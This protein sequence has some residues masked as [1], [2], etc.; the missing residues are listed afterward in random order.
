LKKVRKRQREVTREGSWTIGSEE[1]PNQENSAKI[2]TEDQ[3]IRRPR[4]GKG[5]YQE[6]AERKGN[7]VSG[8]KSGS[9]VSIRIRKQTAQTRV[10]GVY[11]RWVGR[12]QG[13]EWLAKRPREKLSGENSSGVTNSKNPEVYGVGKNSPHT[14]GLIYFS[15]PSYYGRKKGF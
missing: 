2:K 8:K 1:T 6:G 3:N 5:V 9:R 14:Q 13:D 4:L 12:R 15:W 11:K 10:I 7:Y